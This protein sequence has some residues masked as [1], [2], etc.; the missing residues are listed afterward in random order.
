ME[1]NKVLAKDFEKLKIE[2]QSEKTK[3]KSLE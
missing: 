2:H 3:V 1:T